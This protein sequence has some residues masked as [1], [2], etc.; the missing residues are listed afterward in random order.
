MGRGP[1][2][3]DGRTGGTW[4]CS[5][6]L[7]EVTVGDTVLRS[8]LTFA[9]R[10]HPRPCDATGVPIDKGDKFTDCTYTQDGEIRRFK[11]LAVMIDC[12]YAAWPNSAEDGM[13]DYEILDA[14]WDWL[15]E[16]L[17]DEEAR[18]CWDAARAFW[19]QPSNIL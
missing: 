12:A 17:P 4:T 9:K 13:M 8:S 1:T 10:R 19:H 11:A 6:M 5:K 16:R 14:F 3:Q 15:A 2:S 7:A 18:L